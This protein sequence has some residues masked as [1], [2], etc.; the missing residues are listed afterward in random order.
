VTDGV[1]A[2]PFGTRAPVLSERL[3][4]AR[5]AAAVFRMVRIAAPLTRTG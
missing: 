2:H 3:R 1:T 4:G 5:P